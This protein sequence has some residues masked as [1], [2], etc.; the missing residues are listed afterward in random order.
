MSKALPLDLRERA[1]EARR[2]AWALEDHR[3]PTA[4]QRHRRA[5]RVH[6]EEKL[7]V[8]RRSKEIGE[9]RVSQ[10]RGIGSSAGT[11]HKIR[12][13]IHSRLLLVVGILLEDL[14]V[15]ELPEIA[16]DR[17]NDGAT[18]RRTANSP[19][20]ESLVADNP[21]LALGPLDIR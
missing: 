1:V 15:L 9:T 16:A 17:I 6:R 21:T 13:V 4:R 20:A 7:A 11:L 8:E 5:L 12:R 14:T 18:R 10:S 3:L 19:F 2:A